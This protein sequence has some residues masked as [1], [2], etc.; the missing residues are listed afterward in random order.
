MNGDYN[1]YY[2]SRPWTV[3]GIRGDFDISGEVYNS[4]D[5]GATGVKL[6]IRIPTDYSERNEYDDS[7]EAAISFVQFQKKS[8]FSEGELRFNKAINPGTGVPFV[9]YLHG[10]LTNCVLNWKVVS[11]EGTWP[12]DR[13]ADCDGFGPFQITFKT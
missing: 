2:V 8:Y 10:P 6:L 5:E 12:D 13:G 4:G 9:I 7:D 3:D 1:N 11:A